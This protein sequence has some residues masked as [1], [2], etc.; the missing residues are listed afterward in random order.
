MAWLV[1]IALL[2]C[3]ALL[4]FETFAPLLKAWNTDDYSYCYLVP[5]LTA[6]VLHDSR[7][8][9]QGEAVRMRPA[10]LGLLLLAALAFVAGRA[11]SLETLVFFS[12]WAGI[13]GCAALLRGFSFVRRTWFAWLLLLFAIPF[14]VFVTRTLSLE[15]RVLSSSIAVDLLQAFSVP[16][17]R[18]GNVIDLGVAQLQVIDACSGLRF[19]LPTIIMALLIGYQGHRRLWAWAALLGL[20]PVIAVLSNSLRIAATGALVRHVSP[21]LA[22]G[23]SHDLAGWLVFVVSI[24]LLLGASRLLRGLEK[25]HA[26]A[27]SASAGLPASAAAPRQPGPSAALVVAA[28]AVLLVAWGAGLQFAHAQRAVPRTPF[29]T[30]PL[31]IGAWQGQRHVLP[32]NVLAN[33]WADDY[34]TGHFRNARTGNVLQLLVSYYDTQTTR[35]TAHAPTSCL[36]GGGWH[37]EARGLAPADPAS[38]RDFSTSRMVLSKSEERILANF[39]FQ[40]RGRHIT[41]EFENKLYLVW[42]ALTRNRSDGALVRVEMLL[43]PGQTPEDGQ[44]ILDEFLVPLK[45]ALEPHIPGADA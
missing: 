21:E 18:E 5:L 22:E 16:A 42:D 26:R 7:K 28:C 32:G 41:G 1:W 36:L 31:A 38:G 34:V 37:I 39:W 9:W 45:K 27:S 25:A 44:R 17:Y 23:A 3:L 12:L 14:P 8:R 15:L 6:Y 10:G 24:A 11:G 30:F 35:H 43:L 20:A 33:L 2:G 4:H 13:A 29:T 19:L 40:Q